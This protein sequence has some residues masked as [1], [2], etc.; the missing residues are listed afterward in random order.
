MCSHYT[1]FFVLPER[2]ISSFFFHCC[3]LLK[4][5]VHDYQ[6]K[7]LCSSCASHFNEF[8]D[9]GKL[10][11]SVICQRRTMILFQHK[12]FV[13]FV[14][15]LLSI[16]RGGGKKGYVINIHQMPKNLLHIEIGNGRGPHRPGPGLSVGSCLFR[17]FH[18][19]ETGML[20]RMTKARVN[21]AAGPGTPG[22][23][24]R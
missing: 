8:R 20:A 10:S 18:S 9:G 12:P 17:I 24:R 23:S 7:T 19:W 5:V 4:H 21:M 15:L 6:A 3:R 16:A 11:W 1:V 13:F 2:Y 22:R 14:A